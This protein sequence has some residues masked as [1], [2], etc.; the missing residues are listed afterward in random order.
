M[1]FL[2]V[3]FEVVR[4]GERFGLAARN[5]ARMLLVDI[6]FMDRL[7][8]TLFV[9]LPLERFCK[10]CTFVDAVLIFAGEPILRYDLGAVKS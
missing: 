7:L 3:T 2:L 8:V 5:P 6:F 10:T 9:L 4:P 1:R